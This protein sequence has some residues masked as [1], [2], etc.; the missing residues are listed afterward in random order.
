MKTIIFSFTIAFTLL[1]TTNTHAEQYLAVTIKNPTTLEIQSATNSYTIKPTADSNEFSNPKL[2]SSRKTVGW[3]ELTEN[4]CTSYK[5][6]TVLV[7]LK[8]HKISTKFAEAPP[9]MEWE[10]TNDGSHVKY[11]QEWPHGNNPTIY[12]LRKVSDGQIVDEFSCFPDDKN[13]SKKPP[14]WI[15]SIADGCPKKP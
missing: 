12:K 1:T 10:F 4:C 13:L 6:A 7:I 14:K 2:S 15:F 5:L 9:I 8:D 3:L 11:R